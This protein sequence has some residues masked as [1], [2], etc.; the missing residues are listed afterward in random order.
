[1]AALQFFGAA[2]IGIA[3]D[4]VVLWFYFRRVRQF[5]RKVDDKFLSRKAD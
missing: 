4:A 5:M 2:V 1:M 3:I